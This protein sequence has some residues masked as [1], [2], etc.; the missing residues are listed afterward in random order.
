MGALVQDPELYYDLQALVGGAQRNKLLRYY[1][2]KTVESAEDEQAS[3]YTE[4]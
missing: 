3:A 4:E 1:V 2:R